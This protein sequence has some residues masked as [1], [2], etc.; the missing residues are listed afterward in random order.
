MKKIS[1]ILLIAISIFALNSCQNDIEGTKDLNYVT[2]ET[3]PNDVITIEK[4]TT[5]NYEAH[6][7][8]T[9]KTSSARTFSV[10]VSDATTLNS[11]S[12]TVPA[13]VSIPANSNDGVIEISFS[14]NDLGEDIE[15]LVLQLEAESGVFMGGKFTLLV[16]KKC[17]LTNGINDL[18]GSYS[19]TTN[20]DG[21]ENAISAAASGDD[22][23][24][25]GLGQDFITY[26]WGETV[27]AGGTCT[28]TVDPDTGALNI[29]RQYIFTTDYAGDPY[30]YEIAG[31][32]TWGNCGASPT[33]TITYDIYYV[34]D[35]DGLAKSYSSYLPNAYLNGTFTLD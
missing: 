24:I 28:M 29:P 12:F 11:N 30:D 5:V 35:A 26:F 21:Y 34:G 31:S 13:T 8:T 7:Y 27:T 6:V 32:G 16:Q 17:S 25:T 14:D 9:Q 23:I 20:D 10:T 19:V 33:L 1:Y 2:F 18:V 22:L 4:N 3:S 15:M